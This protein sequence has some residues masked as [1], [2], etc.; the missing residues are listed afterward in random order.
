MPITEPVIITDGDIIGV[1]TSPFGWNW[2]N[3]LWIWNWRREGVVTAASQGLGAAT[4]VLQLEGARVVIKQPHL[5]S[6]RKPPRRSMLIAQ[7]GLHAGGRHQRRAAADGWSGP[8][9]H[10]H[11]LDILARTPAARRA[12]AAPI[13]TWKW[14][15]ATA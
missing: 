10:A 12:G 3:E 5:A 8:R 11:G 6:F 1:G 13:S 2:S 14:E 9:R 4:R 15:K 7:Q